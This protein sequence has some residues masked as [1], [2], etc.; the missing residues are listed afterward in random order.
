MSHV[1]T[2]ELRSSLHIAQREID[3]AKEKSAS[4]NDDL[5]RVMGLAQTAF[6][7]GESVWNQCDV[8]EDRLTDFDMELDELET[9]LH[10]KDDRIA[11]LEGELEAARGFDRATWQDRFIALEHIIGK[12]KIELELGLSA[13]EQNDE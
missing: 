6:E 1:L 3:D 4:S 13:K 10:K 12:M 5:E 2:N 9:Q 7:Y 11:E 8:V